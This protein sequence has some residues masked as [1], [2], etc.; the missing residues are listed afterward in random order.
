MAS[1][2]NAS[3]AKKQL[4]QKLVEISSYRAS[5]VQTVNNALGEELQQTSGILSFGKPER[6]RWQVQTPDES[7]SIIDGKH[8][9]NIDPFVEQVTILNQES[10]TADNPLALLL[11]DG[12]AAWEDV[13]VSQDG[14]T[15]VVVSTVSDANIRQLTLFFDEQGNLSRFQTTDTQ[16]QVNDLVFSDIQTNPMLALDHF[17]AVIPDG[18]EIDDQR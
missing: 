18:Y 7:L 10:V 8:I 3:E 12:D 14:T 16:E 5:F 15:F 11:N 13:E 17:T 1:S 2:A 4:R 6:M 9:Y